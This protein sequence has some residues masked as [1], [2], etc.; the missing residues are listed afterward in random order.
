MKRGFLT[1][2]LVVLVLATYAKDIKYPVSAIPEAL[3]KNVN[4]VVREDE[5]IFKIL[6]RKSSTVHFHFAA[7]IFNGNAQDLASHEVYYDKKTKVRDLKAYVYNSEG[8][9]IKKL[10][11]SEIMDRSAF[12]GF[13][14]FTDNRMKMFDLSQ[15]SYPYT[16]EF[17]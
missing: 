2:C 14:L 7:T 1:I 10:K 3:K 17:E 12:D 15:G 16:V 9:L 13:S 4:V 6:S 5:T 11:A 8:E